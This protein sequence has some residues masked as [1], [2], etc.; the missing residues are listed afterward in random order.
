MLA[1]GQ[2]MTGQRRGR[3]ARS[4]GRRCRVFEEEKQR[5]ARGRRHALR[6][7]DR[8]AGAP[9]RRR[10]PLGRARHR[11]GAGGGRAGAPREAALAR[12]DR[13]QP[14]RRVREGGRLP[15]RDRGGSAPRGEG[16]RG[17]DRRGAG[18]SS[19]PCRTRHGDGARRSRPTEEHEILA[20]VF[21]TLVTDGRAGQP[22]SRP[23]RGLDA[24]GRRRAVPPAAAPRRPASRTAAR[25]PP[26]PSRPRSSARSASRARSCPPPS[27]PIRGSPSSSRARPPASPGSRRSVPTR[28]I[29]IRLEP[30]PVYPILPVAAD[31]TAGRSRGARA[32]PA[33]LVGTGPFRIVLHTPG[34][35]RPRAQPAATGR[36]PA[37]ASTPSSSAPGC[38]PRRSPTGLRSGEIDVARDLLPAGPR[39]DPPRAALPRR[40][41]RDAKEE[42][43]LRALHT[44]AS[45]AA[46]N[47]ALRRALAGVAAH[48]GLRLGRARA[49]RPAGRRA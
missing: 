19:S 43:V 46:A 21:E 1:Q 22:R 3:A 39:G 24:R 18:A 13:G 23:V 15:A 48:A 33:R 49:V 7:R 45:P 8:V 6:R 25:S 44:L 26:R 47:P 34:R 35:R 9:D 5:R 28:E 10:P 40:A 29:E 31:R 12:R 32:T 42:H 14:A 36:R 17:G 27:R 38:A 2:R 30:L 4:R 37:R 20:N 11:I 16:G 41:R